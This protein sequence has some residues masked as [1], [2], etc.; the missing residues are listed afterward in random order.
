M[1]LL[2]HGKINRYAD[3]TTMLF[4]SQGKGLVYRTELKQTFV[5][6]TF[7]LVSTDSHRKSPR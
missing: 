5:P 7:H 6:I 2:R 1:G 4:H 3:K